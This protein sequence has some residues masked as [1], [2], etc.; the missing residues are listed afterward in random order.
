MRIKD[1]EA[2]QFI[3]IRLGRWE[4]TLDKREEGQVG[5]NSRKDQVKNTT[6]YNFLLEIHTTIKKSGLLV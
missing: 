2:K 1:S 4:E 3:S 6:K 5:D